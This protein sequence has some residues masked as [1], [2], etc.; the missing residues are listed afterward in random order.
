VDLGKIWAK[1]FL[2]RGD[3]VIA[4]ARNLEHID[5]LVEEFGDAVLSSS[6]RCNQQSTMLFGVKKASHH[7]GKLD[8]VINNAVT[9]YLVRSKK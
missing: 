4:T 5:D 6:I 7:F 8:V 9:A 2:R 1:A 3:N